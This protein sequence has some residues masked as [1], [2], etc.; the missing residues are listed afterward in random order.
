MTIPTVNTM[1]FFDSQHLQE[2]LKDSYFQHRQ[3]TAG[4]FKGTLRRI[5][6]PDIVIDSGSY[7]LKLLAEGELSDQT[8]ALIIVHR[9]KEGGI[10]CGEELSIGDL[11]LL[12]VGSE[13]DLVMPEGTTWSCI[14]VPQTHLKRYGVT[15]LKSEIFHL[16]SVNF[17]HLSQRYERIL[18]Y[19][20]KNI[21]TEET[22]QDMIISLLLNTIEEN[23]NRIEFRYKDN[24]LVALNIKDYLMEHSE[25][26][27]QMYQLCELTGKSVRTIE[28]IF[29]QAFSLSIRDF[30]TYHR[31][32]LIRQTLLHDKNTTVSNA[33]L[34]YGY[35]HL[36]RFSQ[37]YK[38]IFG[39]LP[40]HTLEKA[41]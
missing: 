13:M 30:H 6:L 18:E 38:E 15:I 31:F 10:L 23:K 17:S 4:N 34:K 16:N 7:N 24:Y 41:K 11:I 27:V 22:L 39:E 37:K 1:T 36:G 8:V 3:V 40:S 5:E 26:T 14:N 9:M 19:L 29:K 25:S 21:F 2:A 33:A 28:R 20:T 12:P 32:A 35:M